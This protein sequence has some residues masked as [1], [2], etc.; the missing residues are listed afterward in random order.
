MVTRT[1][2][3]GFSSKEGSLREALGLHLLVIRHHERH[4]EKVWTWAWLGQRADTNCPFGYLAVSMLNLVLRPLLT[5]WHPKLRSWERDNPHL[6][7]NEWEGRSDFRNALDEVRVQL[8]QY[9]DLFAKVADVPELI[10]GG[11]A[12][13]TTA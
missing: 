11:D 3:G 1:P 6:D 12:T 2:L 10:E 5:E 4:L 8:R 13:T 7:E 9:A